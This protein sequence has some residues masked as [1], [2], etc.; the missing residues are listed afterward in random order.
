MTDDELQVRHGCQVT[1]AISDD[2]KDKVWC[3]VVLMCVG[4]V[5][6]ARPWMYGENEIYR[7]RDNTDIC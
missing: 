2:Y 6:L 3:H 5:L 4:D 7:M 1:F